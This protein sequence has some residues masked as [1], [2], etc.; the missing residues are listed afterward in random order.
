MGNSKFCLSEL[1]TDD[2]PCMGCVP[3]KRHATCHATC[4]EY[5]T[6][7]R[8]HDKRRKEKQHQ[9]ELDEVYFVG[10]HRRN[11]QLKQKGISFGRNKKQNNFD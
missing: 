5:R 11:A 4:E 1:N 7:E 9:R 3:P 8:M 2:C 6:W 10:V